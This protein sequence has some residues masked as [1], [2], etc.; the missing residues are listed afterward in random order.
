[1]PDLSKTTVKFITALLKHQAKLWLGEE[2]VGIAADTFIDKD[3]QQ[4][5]EDWVDSDKNANEIQKAVEQTQLYLQNP[6][7]CPDKDLR[8][9]FRD[10]TFGDLP[11]VQNALAE[12]PN[13]LDA[14]K[15]QETLEAA[16]ARDLPNLSPEQQKEGAR[17][18]TDALLRAVGRLEK[19]LLPIVLQT[20]LDL[21]KGQHSQDKK[22]DVI[23][24]LVQEKISASTQPPSPTLPGDLPT[25]SY[26]PIQPNPY[27][28][29]R[30]DELQELLSLVEG[31]SDVVI[32]QKALVGMGGLGK[33]Q[34]AVQFAWQ[35]GYKFKGVHW[36]SA[37]KADE[38]DS[39]ITLCGEHMELNLPPD[40]KAGAIATVNA[41]KENGP[42]LVILDNLEDQTLAADLLARLRHSN[43]RILVTTR[44]QD[45]SKS[46][47]KE[48]HLPVFTEAESLAFLRLH[49]NETHASDADLAR[50][51]Q[52][53][54][55]LPL[56]LDLAASYMVHVGVS[57][58]D[59][60]EKL[61][62]DHRSLKNWREKY[63]NATQHDK[64]VAATF[65][66]SWERIETDQARRLLLLAGYSLPN[67]PI[68]LEV[69]LVASQL[70]EE[71][72]FKEA[73]AHL[74]SLSLLQ[75]EPSLHP[76]LSEFARLQDADGSALFR[77]CWSLAWRCYPGNEH[78]GI[79]KAG[80][81]LARR[82]RLA[83]PEMARAVNLPDADPRSRSN[84]GF[85]AAFLF[86][87]FGDLNGAMKLY[88]QSLE[89]KEGLGDLKGKAST[90]AMF[91][92][93]MLQQKNYPK[94]IRMLLESLQTL[95]SIGAQPDV[96]TVAKILAGV[97]N[98]IGAE[99]FDSAWKEISDSPIPDW[100]TQP[101]EEGMTVENFI[102]KAIH[103]MKEKLPQAE[104]YLNA[105]Q[106]MAGDPNTPAELQ[107]LGKVL[108]KIL[109]EDKNIDLTHLPENWRALIE[110]ELQR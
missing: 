65:A 94:A 68:P 13:T 72:I 45:W 54:G 24:D 80:P 98:E 35:A 34:L 69:L 67:E 38:I 60:L 78:L 57:V 74:H 4:R 28:T 14:G 11:S 8:Y 110:N 53:L 64:D 101:K 9:L 99:T 62:L 39:S 44:Q 58:P 16:F 82:A 36:V 49:L 32:N 23:I 42:R 71:D 86:R 12:L 75:P 30:V 76:L 63:P 17:L 43:I 7:N 19:F 107:E 90:L 96:E 5:L 29:G 102:A 70:D 108:Q 52:K 61:S 27:F 66:L 48:V 55:G 89:I 47:L 15:L 109:L 106:K 100:L 59:Y 3:L 10:L 79:Y 1:M 21:K 51:H 22:L 88:E 40:V 77:W 6:K 26:L 20:V 31:D 95:S 83:L 84:L 103:A 97:R 87:H 91:G 50:L 41:W 56:P 2:T 93:V 73:L 105:A 104:S 81:D 85:N 25:G 92:Q 18:Y 37:V 46:H 33:T